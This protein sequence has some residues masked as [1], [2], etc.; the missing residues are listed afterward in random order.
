MP[1]LVLLAL[2]GVVAFGNLRAAEQTPRLLD[3][4]P[5]YDLIRIQS[6]GKE[7]SLKTEILDFPGGEHVVP[8]PLPKS[9]TLE[10]RRLGQSDVPYSL[11]WANIRRIELWEQM[12]FDEAIR[13]TR[14]GDFAQGFEYLAYL[15]NYYP[16]VPGLETATQDH[17][18][19]EA[20]H[21]FREKQLNDSLFILMALYE[22]NPKH[23]ALASA[24]P[25][26]SDQII[27]QRWRD[28]EYADARRTLD[29]LSRAFPKLKPKNISKWER[30]F[31][32]SA[33][34]LM[35][36]A[37]AAF[38]KKDFAAARAGVRA[39]RAILPNVAGGT[40]LLNR[41][42]QAA[43]EIV[44]GVTEFGTLAR[45]S[46]ITWAD[47]RTA[48]L[49]QPGLIELTKLDED[50]GGSGAGYRFRWGALATD[51]EGRETTLQFSQP[52]LREGLSPAQVSLR[53]LAMADAASRF[54]Q[55]E[56]AELL[57]HVSLG[58]G[59]SV[60]V[61]WKRPYVRPE[62][63]LRTPLRGLTQMRDVESALW[64]EGK[65]FP[66]R[67]WKTEFSRP[68]GVAATG[69]RFVVEKLH[70]NDE[71]ALAALAS[72][73]VDVLDRVPPW[74]LDRAKK[75]DGVS[76]NRYALP[77]VHVLAVN[78]GRPVLD[79]REFRRALCFAIDR[80]AVVQ[81]V[82]LGGRPQ[83]GFRPIS[84]PFPP[85]TGVTD[86]IAYAYKSELAVRSY[87]PT[88]A[89][90]LAAMAHGAL[91]KQ[92]EAADRKVAAEKA[93]AEKGDAEKADKSN[94]QED[95]TGDRND[96]GAT[97]EP[98]AKQDEST[99]PIKTEP[100]PP[101]PLMLLHSTDPVAQLACQSIKLYLDQAGIPITLLELAPDKSAEETPHDL[102]YL[103]LCVWEPLVDA[104]RLLGPKGLAGRSSAYMNLALTRLERAENWNEA[105]KR[106]Q[107]IHE[108]AHFD[109]PFIPLWQTMSYFAYRDALQGVGREP[110]TLYQ[111]VAEW[112]KEYQ[113]SGAR[114]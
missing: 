109:L 55:P 50:A 64:F 30:R 113:P 95:E 43:P 114:P 18:L 11:P 37:K 54:Y 25:S 34:D 59:E 51:D 73:D 48:G 21:A 22:R 103:E 35:D 77:T 19:A 61:H 38:D 53:I 63:L 49:T 74:Q 65:I 67:P 112:K 110:V 58:E 9:G 83:A 69:P 68:P 52:A 5:E 87:E 75:M 93:E 24:V 102:H 85:G 107:D 91:A 82:L 3:Q 86:P 41:I 6:E 23:A 101:K 2:V 88:L 100:T 29:L 10:L 4:R 36:Q 16:R 56:L 60:F 7:V 70:T 106:L 92:Q 44:V 14:A 31:Q 84:G 15:H 45:T 108:I 71:Q 104:R 28:E 39:A 76:V 26:I 66:E 47:A 90:A 105:T 46:A 80:D 89:R 111:D 27:E 99:E 81:K 96:D 13:L 1:R 17:L 72:G 12:I 8:N 40:K 78:W 62:A 98:V 57:D 42:Q 20:R 94:S 32:D 33:S 97:S 79:L